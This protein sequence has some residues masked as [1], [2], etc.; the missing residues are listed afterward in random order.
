MPFPAGGGS[1]KGLGMLTHIMEFDFLGGFYFDRLT[2]W[3]V[4]VR[5]CEATLGVTENNPDRDADA[6]KV[7]PQMR[8][9]IEGFYNA[10]RAF[11]GRPSKKH[12]E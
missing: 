4:L 12:I 5:R 11:A 6:I 1:Q 9:Y 3:R 10:Q 8:S 7:W 2:E